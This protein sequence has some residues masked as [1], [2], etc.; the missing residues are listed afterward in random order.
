[1]KSFFLCLLMFVGVG[2]SWAEQPVVA[3]FRAVEIDSTIQIGYGVAVAEVNGDDKPD[4]LLADK[5]QIVWYENPGWEKHVIAENLTAR[6]HVC[7]AAQDLDGDGKCEIAVGAGWNPSD[8][9][10]SGAVFYLIAPPDRKEHWEAIALPHE[11]TVHRMRWMKNADE[12]WSLFV[13]P[14]HGRGND[15]AKG[16]GAGVKV[17][18]YKMPDDPRSEWKTELWNESLHK[19]HNFDLF[20][21]DED[22]AHEILLGGKEGVIHLDRATSKIETTLL[23]A[24]QGGGV[25]E[26]RLGKL[27]GGKRFLA[28]VEP[29]HGNRLVVYIESGSGVDATWR[30]QVLDESL[31][32][33]HAL[34]CA[35]FAQLGFD[36][37]V[38]GW[39]AMNRVGAKVG[40]KLFTPADAD[41]SV[42]SE[43][44]IDDNEMACEDLCVADL[45]GDGAL[46]IVASGRG[47]KNVKIYFNER[48][49]PDGTLSL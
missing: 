29:M 20:Q 28:T 11:P 27:G 3:T 43:A 13:V 17:L 25:G 48:S 31:I 32:D 14:L 2:A 37:I 39:R 9:L 41:G 45:N 47:T 24:S 18:A 12:T 26:V 40:I 35:D 1:M 33:A 49:G 8:T 36:Q 22:P 6:D 16:E 21:S 15:A 44:V 34:A 30:P 42:W 19:T 23:T 10:N 5:N 38:I 4:I 7:I 46:D